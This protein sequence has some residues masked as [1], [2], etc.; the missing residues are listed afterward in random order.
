MAGT[1][2]QNGNSAAGN[3]DFSRK[4]DALWQTIVAD[5]RIDR[6][7]GKINSRG[8]PKLSGQAA[9]WSTPRSSDGAKGGPN[10][11]FGAGGTPLPAQAATWATPTAR[12]VKG[13]SPASVTRVN[14]KTR[15]DLLDHQAEQGFRSPLPV[16]AISTD[17]PPS[18]TTRPISRRLFR[19]AMSNAP[20]TTMR[21]WLRK[22]NWRKARLNP[23]FVSHLMGWPIGHALSSCSGMA[24][25]RSQRLM[26]G[27]LS[28]LPL[29]S[30][31]WIWTETETTETQADLFGGLAE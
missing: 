26:R 2:A 3:N 31:P 4:A 18:S 21:R 20:A 22:G 27:A 29:A 7:R 8:E 30:G 1:P 24:F 10:M 5:D 9:N 19:F 23:L 15:M 6:E 25:T 17:G 16:P 28:R 14:G 13:S 11:S 12:D